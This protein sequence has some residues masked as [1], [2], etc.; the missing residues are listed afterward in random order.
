MTIRVATA[1]DTRRAAQLHADSITEGFLPRLGPRFLE[2]L[3]R[4]VVKDDGSFLLVAENTDGTLVGMIAGTQDTRAL[5]RRFVRRDGVRAALVAA[6]RV[7]RN[8]GAVLETL[9][10]GGSTAT[11]LPAAELL[12]LAVDHTA[13]GHG[14][15][16]AL[17]DALTVEFARR[18]TTSSR[19]VVGAANDSALR[20]YRECGYHDAS[21]VEVHR[22]IPSQVLVWSRPAR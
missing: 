16:R 9:R 21:I 14:I 22:N 17:V 11:D 13:R 20:L 18:G 15:G 8:A 3:Y 5:Y 2:R 19:V 4:S 6:P 10:Y 12:A 1:A 7:L